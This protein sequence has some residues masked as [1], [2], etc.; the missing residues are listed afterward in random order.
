MNDTVAFCKD[1]TEALSDQAEIGRLLVRGD[2]EHFEVDWDAGDGRANG[3]KWTLSPH[4]K[5]APTIS[6]VAAST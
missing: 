1:G 4:V 3:H 6:P 5:F 2:G